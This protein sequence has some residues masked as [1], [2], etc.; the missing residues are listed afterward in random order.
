MFFDEESFTVPC[1]SY[2]KK[3][4][5][6]DEQHGFVRCC[7]DEKKEEE[8]KREVFTQQKNML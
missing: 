1:N 5:G 7:D 8:E 4:A 2:T 3:V 6:R